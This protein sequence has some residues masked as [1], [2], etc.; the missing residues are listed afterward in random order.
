MRGKRGIMSDA[1][2]KAL[3]EAAE[4]GDVGKM[5]ALLRKGA[6]AN[7]RGVSGW[8]VAVMAWHWLTHALVMMVAG[9]FG[10]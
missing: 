4:A 5:A 2:E 6:N 10:R 1:D 3:V 8:R 7:C 9:S